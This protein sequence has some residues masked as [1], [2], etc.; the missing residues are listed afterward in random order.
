MGEVFRAFD[1][2]LRVD[3]ALKAVRPQKLPFDHAREALRREVRSARQVVSPNVCRI[4]DL[5][6][7]DGYEL[8][9]MEFI[10][11]E[12]LGEALK[13][14]GPLSLEEARE[15][16]LQFLAGLEAI[17]HAGLR[18]RDFKPDNV[19]ITRAGRVVVMDFGLAR[20]ATA[21][22]T[23]TIAG[24]PAYMS[25]EQARG[26][27]LDARTDVFSAGVVLAEMLSVGGGMDHERALQALW[28]SVRETPPRVPDSPWAPVL[29]RALSA[30]AAERPGSA[31]ELSRAL[32][33]MIERL[34][35]FDTKRPY[36]GLAS[37]TEE[38]AKYFFGRELEVEALLKKL[39]RPRLIALVAPSGAGKSS[40]LRAGLL[41]ALPKGWEALITTP[42]DRPFQ[43]LARTLA[44]HF[45]GDPQAVQSLLRFEEQETALALLQRFR[46]R[47]EQALLIVDQFEELF[48][49]CTS[50]IQ[51]GFSSLLS[52]LVLEADLHV[53]ISLR[54]DFLVRCH[55]QEALAPSTTDL[56]ILGTLSE[57]ALRRA[58][59]QPALSCG[60]RFED[61][62]LVDEIVRDVQK[63]KGALPLLAFAASCLWEKRDRDKGQLTRGAYEEIGGVAGAL[64]K[65]A[66]ATLERIGAP[67]VP[68]VRELFR[69]LVT[70]QGT[71]P[72]RER[73]EL[74]SVFARPAGDAR[75]SLATRADA[76]SVVNAL[77]D[78]RL[79]TSYEQVGEAGETH[80]QIEIV[81]ESLLQAWPRLVRWQTQDADGAQ[82][83]DQLR[84]A[85]QLWHERGRTADLLWTGTAYRDL[86]LWR[87]R[88]QGGLTAVEE[89]FAQAA[90]SL[91]GRRRARTRLAVAALIALLL[92]VIAAVS[93]SRQ[94][95]VTAARRTE[96][97]ELLALGRLRLEDHPTAAL[98]FTIASLERS[99]SQAARRFALEA[100]ARGGTA[101]VL[102]GDAYGVHFSPDGRW[103][104]VGAVVGEVRL[105]SRHGGPP[106]LITGTGALGVPV[107][108]FGNNRVLVTRNDRNRTLQF[109]T[110]P[111]GEETRKVD[112]GERW[113][114]FPRAGRVFTF[115]RDEGGRTVHSWPLGEGGPD[116]LGRLEVEEV[117]D[118]DVSKHAEWVAYARDRTV[119]FRPLEHL[120][121]PRARVLPQHPSKIRWISF[122]TDT[123][124]LVSLDEAGTVRIWR[125]GAGQR[126]PERTVQ[127]LPETSFLEMDALGETLVLAG[128]RRTEA[129]SVWNLDAPP[130]AGPITLR[131]ADVKLNHSLSLERSG[132]W[133]ATTHNEYAVLWALTRSRPHVLRAPAAQMLKVGF[134]P[135]AKW[136]V[137][138]GRDVRLW[139]LSS[140]AGRSRRILLEEDAD[141]GYPELAVS[142]TGRNFL[143]KR[144]PQWQPLLIPFD[145]SALR[146]L[147][148]F[149]QS[150][151]DGL[152]VSRDGRLAA[153]GSRLGASHN[154]IELYD[155]ETWTVRTLDPRAG[156]ETC[157]WDK[158]HE[159]IVWATGF[160]SDGKLVTAG[161]TGLRL[162]N[163]Q[164]GSNT[165]V[166]PCTLAHSYSRLAESSVD[167]FLLV[168]FNE[169]RRVSM[170]TFHDFR[171]RSS[172]ELT[173]HG[174]GV[175]VVALDP[176]GTIAV[177]GGFDGVVRVGPVT[178]EEPHLLVGHQTEV[179][180][181]AVSPDG[182]FIASAGRDGAIRLWPMPTG[183]PFHTLPYRDLIARLRSFT[184]LRV[185]R[186]AL[187][188]YQ[189]EVGPFPGW[190]T[191]PE[192]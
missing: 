60:Y 170:L 103:L 101:Y 51:Q 47:H 136:L 11:G 52:R 65:H 1:L 118:L 162:W 179:T 109:V 138:T 113:V 121:G 70:A 46:L 92:V 8:V 189:Y 163:L 116:R 139:P 13:R 168:E 83:R 28:C 156:D 54:D 120:Q 67:R 94:Q 107:P 30:N 58:L 22:R 73:E 149:S 100:L 102:P 111:D 84:H 150:P 182:R 12:T 132:R 112:L 24:T 167:R 186:N 55:Q 2:R 36:P 76:E 59:V 43:H 38:D 192:W 21:E 41:P 26:D 152:S 90:A 69:N 89:A 81:H 124:R 53:V 49:L 131:N 151:M 141:T 20:L 80:R 62:S 146:F 82:L 27:V 3:I 45:A 108:R 164:S 17:H 110:V 153:G 15:I 6:G 123:D 191:A 125:I 175:T 48:T 50:E 10:D 99:D 63:E 4:F 143:T 72:V 66:E 115:T 29:R 39:R 104:A 114:F 85:A 176:T 155:L 57:S 23:G 137:S 190:E 147:P 127:G 134:T 144:W 71:R 180:S 185:V 133:L 42:G 140:T 157:G 9:S 174:N 106:Q 129:A 93:V 159:G 35:G 40:F 18:H 122:E 95:A 169:A 61:D 181:V 79:L 158:G 184:N 145:G 98:A 32:E 160:T 88:Y 91:T 135:D 178:G 64:A 56:T 37:F 5:V 148:R 161:V 14:R 130:D 165:L 77:L 7:E 74:L 97:G 187:E 34:P 44:P 96:A 33:E 142:P 154:Q 105:W 128:T 78:A 166:K 188:G 119:Y 173:S 172:S 126:D 31:H 117:T 171:N 183:I 68:I 16:A 177:T 87:E 75:N 86:A 25:P 19:M